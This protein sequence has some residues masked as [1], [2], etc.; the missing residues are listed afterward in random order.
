MNKLLVIGGLTAAGKTDLALRLSKKYPADIISADSRQVY[1]GLDLVTGKDIPPDF[2]YFRDHYTNGSTNIYGY[3]LVTPGDAWNVS[4][5]QQYAIQTIKFIWSKGRLPIVVGGTGLYLK[6]L[7]SPFSPPSSPNPQLR[8]ELDALSVADLQQKLI[9]FDKK[10]FSELNNSDQNNPRRL[11]RAIETSMS[12][13]V[14]PTIDINADTLAIYLAAPLAIIEQK[15]TSRVKS[16]LETNL[17]SELE[18]LK[19][20]ANVPA[21]TALGYQELD[22]YFSGKVD[23]EELIKLWSTHERQYAKRQVTWFKKQSQFH[24]FDIT[25]KDYQSQIESIVKSWYS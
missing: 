7:L 2:A 25:S 1:K 18:Y 14:A 6:S 15:I 23:Q 20:F 21:Y 22:D 10:R 5:F 19:T 11:I 24:H 16:R 3:D 4:L 9:S 8:Q 17:R 12:P 13:S